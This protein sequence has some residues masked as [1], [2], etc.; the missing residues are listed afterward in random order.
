[1]IF[2]FLVAL[3][4]APNDPKAL[5]R[6]CQA[7]DALQ[8]YEDA[9]KDAMIVLKIDPKNKPVQQIMMRLNPIIQEKVC[10]C[11]RFVYVTCTCRQNN[12]FTHMI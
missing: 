10:Y 5:F 6:R 7:Y 9:Y 2:P 1:M 8:R 3:E 4:L 12:R 11:I